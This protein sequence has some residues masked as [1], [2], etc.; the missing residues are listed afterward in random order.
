MIR[1]KR[2][3]YKKKKNYLKTNKRTVTQTNIASYKLQGQQNYI[4]LI[5]MEQYY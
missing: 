5:E 1:D 4:I 3:F 2:H